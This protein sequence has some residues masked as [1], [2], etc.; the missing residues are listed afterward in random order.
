MSDEKNIDDLFGNL[1]QA[2][3]ETISLNEREFLFANLLYK[4]DFTQ[5]EIEEVLEWSPSEK[6]IDKIKEKVVE[7]RKMGSQK[8]NADFL[9]VI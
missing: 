2:F 8:D 9:S 5:D 4:T 3:K 1:N 7:W 6:E